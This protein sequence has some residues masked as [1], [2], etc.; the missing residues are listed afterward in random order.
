MPRKKR[1]RD[2]M[3]KFTPGCTWTVPWWTSR[4]F[5]RSDDSTNT[6]AK[7]ETEGVP[8]PGKSGGQGTSVTWGRH[9]VRPEQINRVVV[10]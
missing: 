2:R 6:L 8:R 5:D 7:I 4:F 3:V 10:V 9:A 1:R